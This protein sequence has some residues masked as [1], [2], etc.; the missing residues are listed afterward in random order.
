MSARALYGIALVLIGVV[1]AS[2]G[3]RSIAV[4]GQQ[5]NELAFSQPANSAPFAMRMPGMQN[6][7][8]ATS[9]QSML[10]TSSTLPNMQQQI[11]LVDTTTKTMSVYH[12]APD[13][14]IISLKSV[15]KMDADFALDE[16]NA[17]DPSPSKVRSIINP[18]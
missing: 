16:F 13:T 8:I 14:G 9:N 11:V 3:V 12:I 5:G 1:I 10:M 2:I 17:S 6:P 7:V 15:R 4:A 18:R